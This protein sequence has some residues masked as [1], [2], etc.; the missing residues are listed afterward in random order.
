M[1][2]EIHDPRQCE[3]GEGPLWHPERGQLFWFDILGR[4]LLSRAGDRT[5]DWPLPEICSAAGWIDR[6]TLLLASETGLYRFDLGSG[7]LALV[8][9]LEADRPETRSND[10]RA[11][12]MG[13]FW[14]GTMSKTA[15]PGQGAIYRYCRG[16]LRQ[17]HPGLSI[18]NAICFS[19]DGRTGYFADTPTGKVW[20]QRLDAEGWPEGP[21]P[22]LFL[23]FEAEGRRPD[24]AVVDAE[25]ALWVAQW[26]S[27]RVVR[28]LPDGSFDR[29]IEVGGRN[30]SCPA[31]GGADLA[32]LF[33][34]TACEG[35]ETPDPAQGV[36]YSAAAGVRGRAEPQVV[37]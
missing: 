33:V 15:E 14:I 27:G 18:P 4:R 24:G 9:P 28:H 29:A 25:G 3:L 34:T 21:A 12:P 11:D 10:G 31:F 5:L 36:L 13:G 32:T 17:V 22:E 35:I 2:A 19:A 6:E 20:R 30:S 7:E 1:S 8:A 16:T 26:G 37:L 23:D